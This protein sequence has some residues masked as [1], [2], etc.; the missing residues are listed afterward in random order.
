MLCDPTASEGTEQNGKFSGGIT[1]RFIRSE[2]FQLHAQST[3]SRTALKYVW[4]TVRK[5]STAKCRLSEL[6]SVRGG[7]DNRKFE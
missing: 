4:G 1:V 3:G 7:S 6:I 2:R 5:P